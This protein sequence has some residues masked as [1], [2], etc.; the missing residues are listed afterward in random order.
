MTA[1]LNEEP[2]AISQAAAATPPGLQ[3]VVH[4]CLEKNPER[5]F[6]S[7]SDLA[8][9]LEALSDSGATSAIGIAPPQNRRSRATLL[10]SAV[11]VAVLAVAALVYLL[12]ARPSH[13]GALR[14]V[15]YR[16]ITHD[17]ADK[18]L[19]GTDGSRLYFSGS[20]PIYGVNQVSISGGET[21]PIP[22][23]LANPAVDGVSPDGATLLV[24][25]F[26]GGLRPDYP[27]WSVGTLGGSQHLL[28]TATAQAFS[29]D[30]SAVVY[31]AANGDLHVVRTGGGGDRILVSTESLNYDLS[32]SPDGRTIR[33]A[34]A[35]VYARTHG[36]TQA[37]VEQL[38]EVPA[39]GGSPHPALPGFAGEQHQGIWAQDG[40]FF[41]VSSGQIWALEA[42][43]EF[44]GSSRSQ[45]VQITS[46]PIQWRTPVPGRD[47]NTIYA[48][49]FTARGQLEHFDPHSG[50]MQPFLGGI[51]AD[52]VTFSRD[53]KSVAYVSYPDGILWKANA[54]GSDPL[55]ITD[56]SLYP[57][58]VSIS[59]DGTQVLFEAEAHPVLLVRAW[60]LSAQGGAPQLLLPNEEARKR[61]PTG[62]PMAARSS[63]PTVVKA[64]TIRQAIS[65]S[66]ISTPI[67]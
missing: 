57:R 17:G 29:P 34:R 7:A 66:S 4:R 9:A 63:L 24:T 61:I 22:V 39:A 6:Q 42:H 40:S 53:G 67:R 32:W 8:F 5:R 46:G 60:I 41:F 54:D 47:G 45:P 11:A 15:A 25:S 38:W 35:G 3:R 59:P 64:A 37:A 10:W 49:G 27:L 2:S 19:G 55:Q 31:A 18:L 30:G 33:Y 43:R 20:F 28:G 16:Q 62:R 12:V 56:G 1:I 48:S 52:M 58:I 23:K 26:T 13:S 44:F 14:V 65:A 36:L 21:A 50:R 51:S